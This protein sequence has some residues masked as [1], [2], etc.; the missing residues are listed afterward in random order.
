MGLFGTRKDGR[1]Y[2]KR[3]DDSIAAEVARRLEQRVVMKTYYQV[4]VTHHYKNPD[5]T[6]QDYDVE[7]GP[8]QVTPGDAAAMKLR[9]LADF[10]ESD[11]KIEELRLEV[12]E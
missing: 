7:Y 8:A 6:V 4:V 3:G 11:A 5:G 10:P 12:Y 9:A 2:K 1:V